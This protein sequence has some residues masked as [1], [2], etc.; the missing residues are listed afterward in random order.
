MANI[1]DCRWF[2]DG[3]CECVGGTC[4]NYGLTESRCLQCSLDLATDLMDELP[5]N[6]D[7]LD[8]GEG[9]SAIDGSAVENTNI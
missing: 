3:C 5:E 8:Y 9:M 7:E 4:Q 6:E 2:Y 1:F